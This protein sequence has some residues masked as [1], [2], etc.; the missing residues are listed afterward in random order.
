MTIDELFNMPILE[1]KEW[2]RENYRDPKGEYKDDYWF[3]DIK[4]CFGVE[5][6]EG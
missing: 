3:T 1:M 5:F 2:L 4:E 6:P